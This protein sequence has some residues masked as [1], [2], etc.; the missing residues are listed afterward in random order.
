MKQIAAIALL[1]VSIP[2]GAQTW[3]INMESGVTL[4]RLMPATGSSIA[5]GSLSYGFTKP[6]MYLG[7]EL[8]IK[9]SEHAEAG[10]GYQYTNIAVG[11]T[12]RMPGTHEVNYDKM[13][14]HNFA[15]S[16]HLHK[17]LGSKLNAGAFVK[18]GFAYN[19]MVAMGASGHGGSGPLDGNVYG[20]VSSS[21]SRNQQFDIVKDSWVPITT[22]GFSFYPVK[23]GWV[24]DRVTLNWSATVA[25]KNLYDQYATYDYS[26]Q[27][28]SNT[29]GG[30]IRYQGRPF[31]MQMGLG[32]RIFDFGTGKS[33]S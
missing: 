7:P 30:T 22:V 11:T 17:A 12:H 23:Q 26:I 15:L 16:F 18:A 5:T 20:P 27:S 19:N 24:A 13:D 33:A 2:A 28:G 31:I 25:W 32:F 1:A 3:R 29:E 9:L 10:F 6:G 14:M 21:L 4:A 8:Q